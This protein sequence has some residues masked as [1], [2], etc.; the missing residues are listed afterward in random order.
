MARL[1]GDTKGNT[2]AAELDAKEKLLID[3][4]KKGYAEMADIN[5]ALAAQCFEVEREVECYYD[6]I[7]ECE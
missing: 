6:Q 3:K 4:M 7:A 2:Q 1:C 5:L